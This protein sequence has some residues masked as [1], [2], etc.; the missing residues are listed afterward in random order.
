MYCPTFQTSAPIMNRGEASTNPDLLIAAM[1]VVLMKLVY[2]LDDVFE[3]L[4]DL[5]IVQDKLFMLSISPSCF[6]H[7]RQQSMVASTI[8]QSC[9]ERASSV[10]AWSDWV[11]LIKCHHV[12]TVRSG[13]VTTKQY[14]TVSCSHSC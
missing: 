12:A 9:V 13:V 6:F 14:D 4:A 10:Y 8:D 1:I 5:L 2:R 11:H 7:Y 3:M